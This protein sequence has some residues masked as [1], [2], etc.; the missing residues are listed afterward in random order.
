MTVQAPRCHSHFSSAPGKAQAHQDEDRHGQRERKDAERRSYDG[1]PQRDP[2]QHAGCGDGD[3]C[4]RCS[5]AAGPICLSWCVRRRKTA[6]VGFSVLPSYNEKTT[7]QVNCRDSPGT[8]R[9]QSK[10]VSPSQ[11]WFLGTMGNCRES[12]PANR[13]SPVRVRQSSS[14]LCNQNNTLSWASA[15]RDSMRRG[16][17]G[18]GPVHR[19][20]RISKTFGKQVTVAIN[21][22]SDAFMSQMM[23]EQMQA[24]PG[25]KQPRR[26]GV[27]K[28]V[29][30]GPLC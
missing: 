26:V 27:P 4:D 29:Y 21:S 25:V 5:L 19:C 22:C 10:C 12:V 16:L 20:C 1:R 28:V 9:T 15:N 11:I 23:L 18:K 17:V 24:Q 8:I 2:G 14:Q 7:F 6:G 3:S 13:G 30:P